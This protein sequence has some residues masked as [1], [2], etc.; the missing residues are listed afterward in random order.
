MISKEKIS[1]IRKELDSLSESNLSVAEQGILS[2]LKEQIEKEENLLSEFENNINQKNY[3]DALTSFFQLIQRTNMMYTYVIQ[4]SILA[5]LSNERI[6]K[7][8]Q[9]TIDCIAQII[10]DIVILF[11]NNMKEMGLES[12]NININSNPPAIS[13]SLAIKSG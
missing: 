4:P 12:L 13:L 10:S 11:K 6:S 1:S 9:D 7:L 2:F 3:G 5:M 8:I